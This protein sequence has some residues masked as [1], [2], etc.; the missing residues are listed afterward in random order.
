[1]EVRPFVLTCGGAPVKYG[2]SSVCTYLWW[3]SGEVWKFVR[4][5]LPVVVLGEV[6]KFVRLYLPD[7][8]ILNYWGENNKLLSTYGSLADFLFVMQHGAASVGNRIPVSV[9]RSKVISLSSRTE[10]R[11]GRTSRRSTMRTLRFPETS[12]SDHPLAQLYRHL[13]RYK[14]FKIHED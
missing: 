3:C 14:H 12:G 9:S 11:T 8:L 4:L 13:L 6:W 5:Y 1:M 2:G 7:T 10:I